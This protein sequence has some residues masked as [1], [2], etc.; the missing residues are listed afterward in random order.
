MANIEQFRLPDIG[1]GLTEGEILRWLVAPGDTVKLNQPVVE[2]ET[3]KA[4]VELPSPYAGTV[5]ELVHAEGDVVEVGS[6]II[7][8]Q[9]A[10]EPAPASNG[11]GA[12]EK[13][14]VLVGLGPK[15]AATV[16]RARRSA[17][18]E[19]PT[20]APEAGATVKPVR[21]GGLEVA[22][23]VSERLQDASAVKVLAKPPVRK[24]AR[25]LG[26]DLASVA[27][28]GPGGVV[29]RSDV[30]RAA[31]ATPA[32]EA[33]EETRTPIRGVRK[34]TAEAMVES[35]FSAPHVTCFLDVDMTA[36][37][38]LV[39]RL[40]ALPDFA[41]V[42]VS[43]LLIAAK[44]CLAAITRLPEMNSSWDAERGEIVVKRYVNLGIAAATA[45]GLLVPNVK[46]AQALS[47]RELA[48]ALQALAQLAR[49]GKTPPGDMQGGT[50]TISNIGVFGVDA[51]TPIIPP[52]EAA[53][54]A[55][56]AV[57]ERP[58][59]VD[60]QLEVRR[61]CTLSLSFDHRIVDGEQG[62]KFL[63]D[64]GDFL[65]DPALRMLAGA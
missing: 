59:V 16:R 26:L 19:L 52:G 28:T 9:T 53:I 27:A 36:T 38:S 40:K 33:G 24:L 4:A 1:E 63:R 29:T 56:G 6:P 49:D 39:K 20:P 45:R 5:V 47:T 51:G 22:R 61:V 62:S 41:D 23:A 10:G 11:A 15:Q 42:R 14:E 65:E 8:V 12:A 2:V 31:N 64:I 46:G 30:E 37:M 25:D 60:G 17:V 50:F 44:A 35:A 58:W 43:P 32:P 13:I 55:L 3:A 18:Q 7:R 34:L 57:R 21:H 48:Q 54:L